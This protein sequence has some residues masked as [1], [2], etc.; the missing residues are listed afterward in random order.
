[1]DALRQQVMINQFVMAAGC[2][3]EHAK[4]FLTAAQWQFETALS[5]FFQDATIPQCRN[6]SNHYPM[7]TPANTPATP[8]S[9]PDALTAL[10]KL[11]T[12]DKSTL[13]TSPFSHATNVYNPQ[14]R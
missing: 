11:S 12:T 10:S 1:M 6:Q 9:F 8:P 7:R 13:A 3:H 4:Q 5:M 2:H 14:S